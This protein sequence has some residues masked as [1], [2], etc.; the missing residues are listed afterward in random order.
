VILDN[1][2]AHKSFAAGAAIEA[3]G[4]RVHFRDVATRYEKP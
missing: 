4:V 1:L 2:P 3:T